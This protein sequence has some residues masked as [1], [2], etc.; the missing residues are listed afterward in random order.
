[1]AQLPG[2]DIVPT[3]TWLVLGASSP[4]ARAFARLV[5]TTTD[6][7]LC[8]RDLV[9]LQHTAADLR[10]RNGK[11]VDVVAFDALDANTHTT[12]ATY[13]QTATAPLNVF[14]AFGSMPEQ[15]D[16]DADPT[17]AVKTIHANYAGAVS[18]LQ[19]IAPILERNGSGVVVVIGSVAGDRG[20]LKNYIYGSAKAGLHTY[21]Q[22][23]RARMFRR[24][25][26]VLTIK[27]GFLDTGMTWAAG[28]LPM[29]MAPEAFAKAVINAVNRSAEIVY[30]P[31]P[32]RWIMAII[33][34]VPES[35]FKRTNI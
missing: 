20:R 6:L 16:M 17:L 27:P 32:W 10:I 15:A 1:M 14:L 2:A 35:L 19:H 26:K 12:L 34:A 33:R 11:R 23:Y 8:G 25:V 30:I 22:G 21:L 3:G 9:D 13:L 7:V 5:G 24:G 28:P 18:I 31:W 29:A 4:I